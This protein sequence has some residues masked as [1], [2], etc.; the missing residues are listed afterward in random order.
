MRGGRS[1][2]FHLDSVFLAGISGNLED[3]GAVSGT[4]GHHRPG[5]GWGCWRLRRNLNEMSS[6][7]MKLS[8]P[9]NIHSIVN[10][11]K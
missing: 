10:N 5:G 7:Q 1:N 8:I 6:S 9:S 4:N 3:D 11:D 2:A